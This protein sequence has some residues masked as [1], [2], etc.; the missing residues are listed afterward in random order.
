MKKVIIALA[1]TLLA[2]PAFARGTYVHGYTR[3]NGTYVQPYHRSSP[4][5]TVTNNYS[6]HGNT[7]PYTGS[8]G[9]NNYT[10]DKTSP[11]FQG[12]DSN[13]NVGH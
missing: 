3:K 7:N 12:A 11:Y 5:G 8:V 2:L 10:H 13:G 1:I 9:T 4:D 6:F